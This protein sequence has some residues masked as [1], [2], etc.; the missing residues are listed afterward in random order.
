[1][2]E[3]VRQPDMLP[4]RYESGTVNLPGIAGLYAGLKFVRAHRAEIEEYELSLCDRLRARLREI[5]GVRILCDDGQAHMAITSIVVP[6]HD[7]G[8]LA[9]ALDAA[10]IAVRA[11]LHCA[12]LAHRTAGTLETGTVRISPS[13]FTSAWQ[14]ERFAAEVQQIVRENVRL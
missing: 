9:D 12:P 4:D 13:V 10:D 2:S 1:M 11:G 3:S 14:V 5:P 6:G 8:A 7:G